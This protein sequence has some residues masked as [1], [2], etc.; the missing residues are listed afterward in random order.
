LEVY[1]EGKLER[2]SH[3]YEIW[4]EVEREALMRKKKEKER[5]ER[6]LEKGREKEK[7]NQVRIKEMKERLEIPT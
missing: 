1:K 3:F 6:S 5:R 2:G 7:K 4:V